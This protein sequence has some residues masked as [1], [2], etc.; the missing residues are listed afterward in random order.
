ME[1]CEEEKIVRTTVWSAG[2]GCH[3]GCGVKLHI[4][5]GKVVKVE[6][7]ENHPWNQGR[8]CVRSL[9][10]TQYIYHPDRV[11]H[12]LKRVGKRGEGK[13][14]RISWD[15]AYDTIEQKFK[16]I[17]D[18]YGAE[19]VIFAQGTGRDMGGP[20]TLLMYAYGSPNWVNYGLSGHC[21]YSPR[22]VAMFATQ[23]D[24]CV[25]DASQF[26][27]KRYDDPQWTPPRVII[28]WAQNPVATDPDAFYGHWIIDCMKRGSK[29]IV[30]DPRVGWI[31]TR[32]EIH[33]QIRPGTDGALALGMLNVIINEG[34]Y[35]K[36]FVDK[37]TFGFDELK[38][39]VQDYPPDK[40]ADI[41]GVSQEEIIKAARLYAN[42]KPAAIQWG[43]PIDCVAEGAVAAQAINHL[44]AITGNTDVPGGNVIARASHGVTSYPYTQDEMKSLYGEELF[45]K[46]SEKRIGAQR[47]PVFKKFRGWAQ[48]DMVLEQI[49]SGHPYPV[50]AAWM[51]SN[52]PLACMGA[53]PR[54]HLS[55]LKKLDFIVVVDL[56]LTPT[57]QALGDIFLPAATYPEKESLRSW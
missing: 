14:E 15:E 34:L 38:K 47:Y 33:L 30:I 5:D 27:E 24:Y 12:P 8:L 44:W 13:W 39:R 42:N 57:A 54:R 52:N 51:Q 11:T 23:G 29:L 37:W 2:P 46:L 25:L 48:P 50:K 45:K 31:A 20:I 43:Q 49:E 21:C 9:A 41:T 26:L 32:A 19:S 3:G 56:F 10:L 1:K 6:G 36:E 17:R 22:Q 7:D 55:A 40:V 4:K 16:D 35:D 28:V 18:K 53:D